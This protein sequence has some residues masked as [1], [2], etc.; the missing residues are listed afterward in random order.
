MSTRADAV[1]PRILRVV[2]FSFIC[3]LTV[4][5][6]LAVVPTYVQSLGYGPILAGLVISVQYVATFLSRA[7]AGRI[8]DTKGPKLA[9]LGGL[10]GCG[11]SGLF[12]VLAA[13]VRYLP[14]VSL[15][16]LII[17]RLVLGCGES[18]VATGAILWGIGRVGSRLTGR[19]ISLN[20]VM[21]YGAIAMGAPLGIFLER[22]FG[23]QSIG[24]TVL[25]VAWLS[26]PLAWAIGATVPVVGKPIPIHRVFNLVL[27]YGM[28]LALGSI[29]FGSIATFITLYYSRHHWENAALCVT[30]FGVCFVSVRIVFG[31][32]IE[33]FG[34]YRVA[35]LSFAV[36]CV[37]LL[38]LW[39]APSPESAL[40]GATL[41][42]IGFSL[43]F[44]ALGVEAVA[45][46]TADNRGAALGLYSVFIDVALGVTG[47][48]G[49]WVASR[50]DFNSIFLFAAATAVA[51]L[52]LTFA[53]YV[54]QVV[55][56]PV[57]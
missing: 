2:F 55:P 52:V 23:F 28:G 7:P 16:L 43:V 25:A 9:V 46:V 40:V 24:W 27:P 35:I 26:F 15:T 8:S 57:K 42:G 17:G 48:V 51:G 3:Y 56:S 4:G 29:G 44:P 11:I 50:F 20:G 32:A 13:A 12:L 22:A 54:W 10:V 49:G 6:P 31:S 39:G 18:F 53:L 47:P 21:T 45:R 30:A 37:G 34:G 19:V 41:T 5:L 38:L 1:T 14:W 33:R 36:E